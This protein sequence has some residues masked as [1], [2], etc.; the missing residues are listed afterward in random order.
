MEGVKLEFTMDALDAIATR[1]LKY[2]TGARALRSIIRD[3]WILSSADGREIGNLMEKS[4]LGALA[5]RFINLIP[6]KYTIIAGTQEVAELKQH[7]NPFIL[8]YTMNI[9]VPQS[10][11][12]PRLL[13][14]TGILLAGI[15][16]RQ[17][18]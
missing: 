17:K 12:D 13:I 1:A 9:I 15:E 5:S 10:S 14:A 7:F 18:N 3:E 2:N 4:L 16:Q 8:R 11:I 6:Q